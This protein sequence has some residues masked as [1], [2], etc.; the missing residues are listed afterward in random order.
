MEA[1]QVW[2]LF[3]KTGNVGVYMLYKRL[4]EQQNGQWH[5]EENKPNADSDRGNS[6]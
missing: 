4:S 5:R 1:S 3:E 2:K 6:N